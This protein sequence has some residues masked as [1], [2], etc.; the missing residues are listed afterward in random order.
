DAFAELQ[1]AWSP[2]GRRIAFV[3]DRFTTKLENLAVGPYRLA[4]LELDSGDVGPLPGFEGEGVKNID[5]QWSA[6]GGSLFFISDR[7]GI[8]NVYPWPSRAGSS[9][10]S[11]IC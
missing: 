7:N 6:D 11:P 5:P 1:P 2:D 9:T 4:M 8:S 3:T 10:R